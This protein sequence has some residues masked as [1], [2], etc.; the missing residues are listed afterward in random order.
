MNPPDKIFMKDSQIQK[1]L[2][3]VDDF[4]VPLSEVPYDINLIKGF[5]RIII[6]GNQRSGTTFTGQAIAKSLSFKSIDEAAFHTKDVD[7]FKKIFK[8]QNIVVQAPGLTHLVHNFVGK[9]DLVIFMVRKWSDIFKSIYRT[10]GQMSQWVLMNDMYDV[11]RYY[12]SFGYYKDSDGNKHELYDKKDERCEAIYDE[13]V[14]RNSFHLDVIYKMWKNFQRDLIPNYIELDYESMK[15][16]PMWV[17]KKYRKE[18]NSKQ[19]KKFA[20]KQVIKKILKFF[21]VLD[22]FRSFLNKFKK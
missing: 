14:D 19:T 1:I 13:V 10:N 8:Q 16:H 11:N 7:K 2:V 22:L 5:E 3:E 12:Y 20:P 6:V 15:L 17:D 9:N 18:F 21:L 4:Q